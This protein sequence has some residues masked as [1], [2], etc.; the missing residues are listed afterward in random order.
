MSRL[1]CL[2]YM[3]F[4][5]LLLTIAIFACGQL[6]KDMLPYVR[7]QT[8]NFTPPQT[9]FQTLSTRTV[10]NRCQDRYNRGAML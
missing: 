6:P 9:Q 7:V 1:N 2:V 5:R 8:S 3:S 10:S 4:D